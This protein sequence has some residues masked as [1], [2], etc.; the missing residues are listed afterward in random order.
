MTCL[1]AFCG[2]DVWRRG[3]PSCDT[4]GAA[5]PAVASLDDAVKWRVNVPSALVTTLD[6]CLSDTDVTAA[7]AAHLVFESCPGVGL[8]PTSEPGLEQGLA[9]AMYANLGLAL[10]KIHYAGSAEA[11]GLPASECSH[12]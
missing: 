11:W 6:R 12:L 2:G 10:H 8:A 5:A 9:G 3:K 7:E 4:W 1:D